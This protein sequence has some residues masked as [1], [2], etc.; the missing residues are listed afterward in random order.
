[1]HVTIESIVRNDNEI[2]VSFSTEFGGAEAFWNGDAPRVGD[3]YAVEV[4]I[5]QTLQWGNTIKSSPAVASC[6][7]FD[8]DT[9]IV[10]VGQLESMDDDGF[11]VIHLGPSIIIALVDGDQACELIG[12]FVMIH[13]VKV[14]LYQYDL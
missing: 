8:N 5:A 12:R 6:I 11:A 13:N 10:I 1:V 3:E 7:T 2:K 9:G 4:E 14:T